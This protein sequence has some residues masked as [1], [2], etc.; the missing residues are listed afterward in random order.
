MKLSGRIISLG[1]GVGVGVGVG[2][3]KTVTDRSKNLELAKVAILE[4]RQL[5][6]FVRCL[7]GPAFL[8]IGLVLKAVSGGSGTKLPKIPRIQRIVHFNSDA[9]IGLC[10]VVIS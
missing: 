7:D 4:C 2:E 10:K 1:V 8:K 3:T 6:L 9:C 5:A